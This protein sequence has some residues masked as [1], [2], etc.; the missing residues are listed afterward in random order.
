M[1]RAF[2]QTL[3]HQLW[4]QYCRHSSECQLI[5]DK[6]IQCGAKTIILDH[7]AI[8][9]LPGPFSGI[10]HL[11][12]LFE[13]CGYETKGK[14]YLAKKQNDFTWL[15]EENCS[16]L[17]AE[18]VLPQIVIADFRLE[19]LPLEVR[20]IVE[21]YSYQAKPLDWVLLNSKLD[22]LRAGN[23]E[24]ESILLTYLTQYFSGR[25]WPLP[26][27]REFQCVHEFNELL[28]W[29]LIFGRRP[30]HF[31]YSIHLL[32]LFPNFESF[33]DYLE[34]DLG[35]KLN[36]EGARIK[37]SEAIGIA[38]SSTVEKKEK[39]HLADGTIELPTS[40]VEFVW[41]YPLPNRIATKWEDYFT[42]F[43]PQHADQII[44][45]LY[46]VNG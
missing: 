22:L 2:R 28:G 34:Q 23:H 19:E 42:G 44:Q 35:L 41:R 11:Q 38:Q 45:S 20:Q 40:F 30:N 26:T 14:D 7:F 3:T 8:I 24:K 25:E 46:V 12:K 29:V 21:K 36:K 32:D 16:H 5:A 31:T 18:Q 6:L 17:S 43:I 15:A 13:S 39:I 1:L 9:D 4:N 33:N 10:P 27:L 37:G